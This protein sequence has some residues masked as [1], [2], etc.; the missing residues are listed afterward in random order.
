MLLSQFDYHLP[1]SLIAQKPVRP[2]DHSRLM[3][4][5]RRR[6]T[7]SHHYF[8]ELPRLLNSNHVLVANN[9]RVFP[10]RLI[11]QKET[12]G[13]VEVLLSKQLDP[14]TWEALAKPGLGL[15]KY[16]YFTYPKYNQISSNNIKSSGNSS[17][18]NSAKE[19][20]DA[21]LTKLSAVVIKAS[22]NEGVVVLKFN[23]SASAVK[24]YC[25]KLGET[26]LPPYI[27]PSTSPR[28]KTWYQTVYARYSGSSAA[29]TAGFH[30]TKKLL[31]SIKNKNIEQEFVT[32]HVGLGTFLPVRKEAIEKHQMHAEWF[33]LS[34]RVAKRL[35]LLK[36][37]GKRITA[38]GTTTTRVLETAAKKT[39]K[40][41]LLR[42]M[43]GS[44]NLYVYPP[45]QLKF[46]D[47]LITNF[48]LP[49]STLL[50]LVSAFISWPNSD[51]KFRSFKDSLIGKAYQEAIKRK[52]RFY[53]FGD[54]MLIL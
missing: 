22:N 39:R 16:I 18:T 21:F 40:Q 7:I 46:V 11:A 42:P 27:K 4:I 25:Q 17:N 44:T 26:P 51:Q 54:A 43:T 30:F 31:K 29:P 10:A 50:M 35:N 5:D 19:E 48:H 45:Y 15:G 49:C 38:V 6:Q 9:T 1:K 32:L 8:Y 34:A 53:S 2:R 52:Y 20:K 36:L 33:N 13:K 47:A 41:S 28:T 14:A 24:T 23:Q 37:A 12:G 3:V